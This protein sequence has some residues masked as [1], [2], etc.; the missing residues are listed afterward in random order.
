LALLHLP[1]HSLAA[2]VA[3]MD[4]AASKGTDSVSAAVRCRGRGFGFLGSYAY[5]DYPYLYGGYDVGRYVVT[6]R[7]PTHYGWRRRRIEVCDSL[8]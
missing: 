3:G 5:G 1:L 2:G 6:R 4:V 8:D 7:I